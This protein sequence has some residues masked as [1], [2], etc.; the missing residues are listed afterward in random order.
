MCFLSW[1]SILFKINFLQISLKERRKKERGGVNGRAIFGEN[2]FLEHFFF[3]TAKV[4]TVIK[5]EGG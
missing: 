3:D 4:P 5:L 2:N 1:L